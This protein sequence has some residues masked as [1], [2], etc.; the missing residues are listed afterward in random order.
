M[1]KKCPPGVFCIETFT[2]GALTI[3]TIISVYLYS[4]ITRTSSTN[5]CSAHNNHSAPININTQSSTYP[6]SNYTSPPSVPININ[7]QCMSQYTQVGILNRS[8]DKDTILALMGRSIHNGRDKWQYY[9]LSDK[10]NA[11]RLPMTYN[12]RSCTADIGIDSLNNGDNIYVQGYNDTFTVTIYENQ[13]LR[14]LP[15]ML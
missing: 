5:N 7:T 14:Y 8:D 11:M 1:T 6:F 9:C 4:G 13:T 10:N 15:Q 2:L 12:G 3:A